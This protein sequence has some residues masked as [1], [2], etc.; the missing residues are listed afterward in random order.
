MRRQK[1]IDIVWTSVTG[2][3]MAGTVAYVM[4]HTGHDDGSGH[5]AAA[6]SVAD[7]LTRAAEAHGICYG[8]HLLDDKTPVSSGSNLGVGA[9]VAEHPDRCPKWIE[10]RGTYHDYPDNS[11]FEDYAEYTIAT[12]AALGKGLDPA[13]LERLDAGTNR[14]LDDPRGTILDAAE[15]LPLLAL[16][17]GMTATPVPERAATGAPRPVAEGGSD[18]LRDR[19]VLLLIGGALLLAAAG[20]TVLLRLLSRLL[21]TAPATG[22]PRDTGPRPSGTT[23]TRPRATRSADRKPSP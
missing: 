17:A 20:A 10:L 3:V 18:F 8:W 14:L 4:T 11:Q 21:V 9:R 7:D 2:V 15:V 1:I 5:H 19:W 13:G 23:G 6:Q 12:S 22:R 16:E